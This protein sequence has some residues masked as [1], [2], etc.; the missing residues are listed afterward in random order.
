MRLRPPPF[1]PDEAGPRM[2]ERVVFGAWASVIVLG[3]VVMIAIPLL[4]R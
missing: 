3:L 1:T 4:G 2:G